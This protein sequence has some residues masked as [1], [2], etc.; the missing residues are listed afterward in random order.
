MTLFYLYFIILRLRILRAGR[1]FLRFANLAVGAALPPGHNAGHFAVCPAHG[2][3]ML[4]A[5]R[6]V[7]CCVARSHQH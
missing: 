4:D 3:A 1:R 5:C 6:L 2:P 7:A